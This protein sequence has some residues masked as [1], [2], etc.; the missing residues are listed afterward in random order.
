MAEMTLAKPGSCGEN[1][2]TTQT[3]YRPKFQRLL[4]NSTNK[5]YKSSMVF[6]K[7]YKYTIQKLNG[8]H[9]TK[10]TTQYNVSQQQ[11]SPP[12][13]AVVQFF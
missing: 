12:H 1:Q 10:Q 6:T 9:K 8:L 13:G 11:V 7:H 2:V 4:Q 3:S 5:Q